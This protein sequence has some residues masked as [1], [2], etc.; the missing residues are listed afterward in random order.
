MEHTPTTPYLT[1]ANGAS[2][3][4]DAN[5]D[6]MVNG[7]AWVLGAITAADNALPLLPMPGKEPGYLT[8]TFLRVQNLGPAHLYLEYSNS[9]G[10]GSWTSV[11]LADPLG[12]I[13]VVV[14]AGIGVDEVTAKIPTTHAASGHLYGRLRATE[15]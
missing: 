9:L 10:S 11:N 15:N 5:G 12:D 4:A 14:N 2:F 6:G 1:W 13:V 3:T 7:M 8:L